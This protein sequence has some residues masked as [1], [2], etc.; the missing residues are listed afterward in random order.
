M[1]KVIRVTRNQLI[2]ELIDQAVAWLDPS[3]NNTSVLTRLKTARA[4]LNHAIE[5]VEQKDG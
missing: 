3:G 4:C 2:Q 5:L 1:G